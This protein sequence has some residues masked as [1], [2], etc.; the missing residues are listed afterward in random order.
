MWQAR[1]STYDMNKSNR[2]TGAYRK[3]Q[4]I[5]LAEYHDFDPVHTYCSSTYGKRKALFDQARL[6]A[7][8]MSK[9]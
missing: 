1:L 8:D 7:Y 4:A 6:N 3:W 9:F 2:A 5:H